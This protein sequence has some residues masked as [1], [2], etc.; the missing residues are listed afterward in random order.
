MSVSSKHHLQ[1]VS[2]RQG[3]QPGGFNGT[4]R[5]SGL[6]VGLLAYFVGIDHIFAVL[7][8][9]DGRKSKFQLASCA[10]VLPT[11]DRLFEAI[12]GGC[13]PAQSTALFED[14]SSGWG[15]KLL[16]PPAS[17]EALDVLVIIPHFVLHGLPFH[18]I[19]W[20]KGGE[21][22]GSRCG[23]V[24]A[25]SGTTFA[26]CVDRN[27]IRR[28][29]LKEWH[30]GLNGGEAAG[31]PPAPRR[32]VAAGIDVKFQHTDEY[33]RLAAIFSKAFVEGNLTWP[34]RQWIKPSV[35]DARIAEVTCIVCHG[36]YDQDVPE[37]SG[38][39]LGSNPGIGFERTVRLHGGEK[40]LF[41]DLPFHFVPPEI[42]TRA[43]CFAEILTI[44]ELMVDCESRAEL[45]A[46]LGCST[47]T[48]RV[49]SADDLV[50]F[51][52]QWLHVGAASVL[53]SLWTLDFDVAQ[54]WIPRFLDNWVV[55]RQ[56][57]AIAWR[58][59]IREEI[60]LKTPIS[61]WAVFSLFGDWL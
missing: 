23:V 36:H 9:Q 19:G 49:A 29:D 13:S 50:S 46:L 8:G 41:R 60:K 44:D 20:E 54:R 11:V 27:P 61:D 7:A 28:H 57:K 30:F 48:G 12:E 21:F 26:R 3:R 33:G 5:V 55:K 51:A 53:A 34:G 32:C 52:V 18:A 56:P 14:F 38:L 31:A 37:R 4:L 25:P 39:L 2:Q 47:A 15:H 42:I 6:R 1:D 40:Y 45:V 58:E 24:Y 16:P 43:E 59:A 10:E 22:L 17:L 35:N